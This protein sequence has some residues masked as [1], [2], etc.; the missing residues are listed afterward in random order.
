MVLPA[1]G[2]VVLVPFPFSDLS[3]SCSARRL[4]PV[5]KEDRLQPVDAFPGSGRSPD[6][7]NA[8]ADSFPPRIFPP[9]KNPVPSGMR[10]APWLL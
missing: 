7:S 8:A 4:L 10:F 1:K 6:L 9:R 2:S 5:L 3:Q